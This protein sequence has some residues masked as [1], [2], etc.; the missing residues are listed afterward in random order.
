MVHFEGPRNERG[1]FSLGAL[2]ELYEDCLRECRPEALTA[3]WLEHSGLQ[4]SPW[5]AV[6]KAAQAMARAVQRRWPEK[7]GLVISPYPPGC[8]A[9]GVEFWVSSHPWLDG[10]ALAAG[11]RLLEFL[12]ETA[13][14]VLFLISGGSSA[15]VEVLL[16]G[17]TPE[18]AFERWREWY[19]SGLAIDEMNDLRAC[20]SAIKGGRLLD[21]CPAGSHSLILCDV[22]QGARWVGSGLTYASPPSDL[23]RLEVLADGG[24]LRQSCARALEVAGYQVKILPDLTGTVGQVIEVLSN[25]APRPGEAFLACSE[26][27]LAVPQGTAGQGGRCQHLV[28]G[29]VEWLQKKPY[30]VVAASSDGRDGPTPALGACADGETWGQAR[31]ADLDPAQYL[32]RHDSYGFFSA[33]GC[34]WEVGPSENNLNDIVMLLH[35]DPSSASLTP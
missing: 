10:R 30:L 9:P 28:L 19:A 2:R 21:F 31:R 20:H 26:A 29:L 13:E 11:R 16:P 25:L 8:P 14:P 27:T 33:L 6:G 32:L 35:R 3:A 17:D 7:P 1:P 22:L 12:G 24:T 5:V 15:L 4:A 23:H 34:S 18:R